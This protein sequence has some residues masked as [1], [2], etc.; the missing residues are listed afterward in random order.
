MLLDI[1]NLTVSVDDK[2]VL[3]N[4]SLSIGFGET[5]LLMG[6]NGSG[7]S[8][9]IYSIIGHPSY[10][11]KEGSIIFKG[12]DITYMPTEERV[13]LGLGVSF[14]FPPKIHGVTIRALAKRLVER[15]GSGVDIEAVAASLNLTNF[16]DREINVGFSGGEMKRVELFFLLIQQ[17]SLVL[18]DEPD[19]GVDVE[20]M[21]IVG[22][23]ISKLLSNESHITTDKP[24]GMIVTHL[25]YIS[26][27]VIT[28]RTYIIQ[29][30]SIICY[31]ET[32]SLVKDVLK[33]GFDGCI[34][35]YG[36]RRACTKHG[37][38]RL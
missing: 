32:E 5:L 23:A 38:E 35:C 27:Y 34:Q 29:N 3:K 21:A 13:E 25:G 10:K 30:G 4:L 24:S 19:S 17:P 26:R 1:R 37:K 8:S 20:N 18:L 31:G 12:E 28:H 36:R 9:L 15:K 11:I 2:Q 6:P 33:H 22:N 16:L 14:Q 7:K